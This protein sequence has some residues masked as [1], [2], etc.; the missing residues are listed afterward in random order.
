MAIAL[1]TTE[2]AEIVRR[3]AG[4]GEATE[5]S[6]A[7]VRDFCDSADHLAQITSGDGDLKNVQR[8][9]AVKTLL[10]SVMPPATLLEV[11]GGEPAIANFLHQLGYKVTIIDP[12]DGSGRGPVEFDEYRRCYPA[13]TLVRERMRRDLRDTIIRQV[14]AVFSI[15]VLEHLSAETISECFGGIA[16]LLKPGGVSLH[17]FDFVARGTG[18]E[19][20]MVAAQRILDAQAALGGTTR[21]NLE[22]VR[23]QMEADVETFY[24]SPQGH[25]WWRCGRSYDEF[26]Y[27]KVASLQ[28]IVVKAAA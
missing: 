5:T 6:Y 25:Q 3:Y 9:W 2:A 12:Y 10:R 24:L 22:E 14:D 11:G 4:R 20:D 17:C 19:H 27:R 26:P 28:T 18:Y 1:N 13:V 23:R 16:E 21:P 7:T 15:S 8:P